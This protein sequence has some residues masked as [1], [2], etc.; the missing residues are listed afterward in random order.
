M[1]QAGHRD[2]FRFIGV[3]PRVGAAVSSY[4]YNVLSVCMQGGVVI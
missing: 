4:G 2:S 1:E 3:I